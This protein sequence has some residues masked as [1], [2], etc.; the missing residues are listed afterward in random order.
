[1][2]SPNPVPSNPNLYFMQPC[3]LKSITPNLPPPITLEFLLHYTFVKKENLKAES[4]NG[5]E[6]LFDTSPRLSKEENGDPSWVAPLVRSSS[7][8]TKVVG[9]TFIRA[10][11][12]SNQ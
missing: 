4:D 7:Q 11:T 6:T 2:V 3:S 12:R 1:M 9:S 5:E 10:H 8:Y